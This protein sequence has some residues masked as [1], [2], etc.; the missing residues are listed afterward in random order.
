MPFAHTVA[1]TTQA[2]CWRTPIKAIGNGWIKLIVKI[3][4]PVGV[5]RQGNGMEVGAAADGEMT[6]FT[7]AQPDWQP[8]M[9]YAEDTMTGDIFII[10]KKKGAEILHNQKLASTYSIGDP[11][12]K[13]GSGT[14]TIVQGDGG[15]AASLLSEVGIVC[16][17]ADRITGGVLKGI[18]DAFTATEPVDICL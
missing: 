3:A 4:D 6:L 9:S 16:G 5:I 1:Y 14:W 15:A 2:L 10:A 7:S 17:P 18:T 11:V 12:Y 13:T 8:G